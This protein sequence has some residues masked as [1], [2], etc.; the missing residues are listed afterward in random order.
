M[1]KVSLCYWNNECV[2]VVAT[3]GLEKP[4]YVVAIAEYCRLAELKNNTI[5]IHS[6]GR[7]YTVV[8]NFLKYMGTLDSCEVV[9]C[10][11]IVSD[12]DY[13]IFEKYLD[14]YG[15]SEED[16]LIRIVADPFLLGV[17]DDAQPEEDR[18]G[19]EFIEKNMSTDA[20]YDAEGLPF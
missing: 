4:E 18:L 13:V 2:C 9:Y 8:S 20:D 10:E 5:G 12:I 6:P 14:H 7:L 16:S 3:K 15:L 17:I 11:D 1:C 19:S